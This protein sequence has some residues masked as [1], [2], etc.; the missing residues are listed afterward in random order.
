MSKTANEKQLGM[1]WYKFTIYF[2]LFAGALLNFV[3]GV[4]YITGIV[5]MLE[6][7]TEVTAEQIYAYYGTALQVVDIVYGILLV[8]IAVFAIVVRQKLAKFKPDSIKFLCVLYACTAVISLAYAIIASVITSQP[9]I[10]T[11]FVTF[12]CN[13]VVM[14]ANIK[15]FKNRSH[16]FVDKN[17]STVG[18]ISDPYVNLQYTH[19]VDDVDADPEATVLMNNYCKNCGMK[20]DTKNI[21]CPNCGTKVI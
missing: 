14:F 8:G 6:S 2:S 9:V 5:Y 19:F 15:Y 18:V 16:L 17:Q 13:L 7:N 11:S 1:K 3:S 20:L 21:F 10:A 4:Q 12:A